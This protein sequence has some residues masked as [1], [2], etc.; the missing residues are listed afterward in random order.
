LKSGDLVV[1]QAWIIPIIFFL[2]IS[3]AAARW[4]D[5][6]ADYSEA[7]SW[8]AD[9]GPDY[10]ALRSYFSDPIFF[11]SPA[12]SI[13]TGFH[14]QYYPYFGEDFFR[15]PVQPIRIGQWMS[16]Q[17]S[18]NSPAIYPSRPTQSE[19]RNSSLLAMEWPEFKKNWT[20]T[21]TLAKKS[22]SLKVLKNHKW[23]S[24]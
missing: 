19:F 23:T 9:E 10:G 11:S 20:L 16:K 14:E 22:S 12:S 2:F 4:L 13:P 21:M 17:I 15:T 6:G 5:E 24:I 8:F 3:I 18:Q 7:A 1:N